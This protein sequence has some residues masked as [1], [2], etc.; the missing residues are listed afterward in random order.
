[1]KVVEKNEFTA[2]TTW[3]LYNQVVL[4]LKYQFDLSNGSLPQV[5]GQVDSCPLI[6]GKLRRNHLPVVFR[7][8]VVARYEEAK[9]R[10][11]S[12]DKFLD[13]PIFKY[14]IS[15]VVIEYNK[16]SKLQVIIVVFRW[17]YN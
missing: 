14:V 6:I 3:I 11:H 9:S 5:L 15:F 4:L 10:F 2:V 8:E 16:R 7:A 17:N 1:M 13:D 12:K